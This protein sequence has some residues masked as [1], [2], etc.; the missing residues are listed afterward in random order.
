[1]ELNISLL[2][3]SGYRMFHKLQYV[4]AI[5]FCIRDQSL[6]VSCTFQNKRSIWCTMLS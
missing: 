5:H 3:Q 2:K 4:T 6:W 1:M